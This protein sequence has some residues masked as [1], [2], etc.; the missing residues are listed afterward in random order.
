M[1]APLFLTL[2]ALAFTSASAIQKRQN[3]AAVAS[4]IP[5]HSTFDEPA[6]GE[7]RRILGESYRRSVDYA[8]ED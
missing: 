8:I 2:Q 4:N 6:R 7:G 3:G 1:I 5:S